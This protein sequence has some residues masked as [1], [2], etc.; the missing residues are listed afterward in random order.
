MTKSGNISIFQTGC[1]VGTKRTEK[2][3]KRFENELVL[4]NEKARKNFP[5]PE[6]TTPKAH[7]FLH[8]H[9]SGGYSK[10]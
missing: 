3:E 4:A 7:H 8:F 2:L 1:T 5:V 6:D 10:V 9:D